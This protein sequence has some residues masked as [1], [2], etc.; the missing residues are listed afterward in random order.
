MSEPVRVGVV[1][2]G[3]VGSG[4]VRLLVEDGAQVGVGD[5]L[6]VIEAMKMEQVVRAAEAGTVRLLVAAGQSVSAGQR[7]ARISAEG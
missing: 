2:M 4:V 6:M 5:G 3:T 7:L 1:G